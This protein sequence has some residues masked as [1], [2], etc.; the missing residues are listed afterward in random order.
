MEV[1]LAES[2]LA[3]S[4]SCT[5]LAV[6]GQFLTP[7]ASIR[8]P[9]GPRPPSNSMAACPAPLA[10]TS[11]RDAPP[12]HGRTA[13]PPPPPRPRPHTAK[14]CYSITPHVPHL[15]VLL[16]E[17]RLHLPLH[18]L[19]LLLLAREVPTAQLRILDLGKRVHD[20]VG[21]WGPPESEKGLAPEPSRIRLPQAR[22]GA[23]V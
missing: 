1:S 5:M 4:T 17:L 22:Q 6:E 8:E 20:F 2:A 13:F 9:L 16:V 19:Q 3:I 21:E 11:C 12:P 14:H 15:H 23:I 7:H 18:V 10:C